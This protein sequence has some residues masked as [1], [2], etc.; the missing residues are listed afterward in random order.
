MDKDIIKEFQLKFEEMK[1]ELGFKVSLDDLDNIFFIRDLILKEGYISHNLSRFVCGRIVET[2]SSWV[3]YL[4][5]I[6]LPNQGSIIGMTECNAFDEEEKKDIHLIMNKMMAFSCQNT[7]IGL[8]KD[9]KI[10]A[11]F[12][13]NSVNQWEKQFKT[14]LIKLTKKINKSW[15]DKAKGKEE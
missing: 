1:K 14:K 4:H 9:K 6:I 10:E 5:G 3:N 11:E 8:E 7:L 13:D 2:Y 15:A 12:I